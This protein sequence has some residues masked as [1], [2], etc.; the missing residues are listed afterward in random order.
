[1]STYLKDLVEAFKQHELWMTLGWNDVLGRYKRSV[2]GPFWITLSMLVTLCAMGPLYGSLFNKELSSFLPH[3]ALGLIFWTFLSSTLIECSSIYNDSTAYLK[4]IKLPASLFIL[5]VLYRQCCILLHNC[6]LIP[7]VFLFFNIPIN[8][9]ILLIIPSLIITLLFLYSIGIIIALFCTRYRDMVPVVQSMMG[10]LFFVTPIL[11]SI[12]QLPEAKQH[13]ISFNIFSSY[14]EILRKPILG[15]IPNFSEWII[16]L[17][18]ALS[19]FVI[20]L[21]LLKKYQHRITFWI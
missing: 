3:L 21:L 12:D 4:Q 9:N 20:S 11:W 14:L 5:R 17:C 10:L 18:L 16:S 15:H 13:I 8:F 1:M 19:L 2:L 6:L 7:L